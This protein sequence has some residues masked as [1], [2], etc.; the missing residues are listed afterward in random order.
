MSAVPEFAVQNKQGFFLAD[1]GLAST[2]AQ[3][4]SGLADPDI[5][6]THYISILCILP[7]EITPKPNGR[8]C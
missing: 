4:D 1:P 7:E 6:W 2:L 3:I 8:L 5:L